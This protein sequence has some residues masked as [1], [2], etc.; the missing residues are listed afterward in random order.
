MKN[1]KGILLN[2]KEK[3]IESIGLK[4]NKNFVEPGFLLT[5]S[6]HISL[7]LLQIYH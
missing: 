1:K 2:E 4:D 3:N 6:S 5:F 7:D